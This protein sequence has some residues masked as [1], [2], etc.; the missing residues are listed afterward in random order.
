MENAINTLSAEGKMLEAIDQ[1]YAENCIFT[2]SDGSSRQSKAE[3][4]AHLTGFFGTLKS[5]DGAKLHGAATSENYGTSQWTFNMTSQDGTAIEWNEVLVR[6]WANGKV[7][8][9]TYYQM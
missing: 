6:N 4:I 1:Y 5:F 7:I 8:S 2:E 3:Q 9:E